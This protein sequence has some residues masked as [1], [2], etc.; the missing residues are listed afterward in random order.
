MTSLGALFGGIIGLY[1]YIIFF[2]K[3]IFWFSFFLLGLKTGEVYKKEMLS[4]IAGCFIYTCLTTILP[5]IK[6]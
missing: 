5:E 3:L 1:I 2:I 4:I 6:A